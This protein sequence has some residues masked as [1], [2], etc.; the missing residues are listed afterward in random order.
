MNSL[1]KTSSSCSLT[2]SSK[3][4]S[5]LMS[6]DFRIVHLGHTLDL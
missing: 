1:S 6:V 5:L 4:S 2:I 3:S